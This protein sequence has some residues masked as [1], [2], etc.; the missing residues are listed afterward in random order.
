M[1]CHTN[2]FT[3]NTLVEICL[4]K[5]SNHPTAVDGVNNM[6]NNVV[7]N[8]VA[9]GQIRS[10]PYQKNGPYICPRCNQQL[11][12][13]QRF[14]AHARSHYKYESKAQRKSRLMS[15]IRKRDLCFQMINGQ[16]ILAPV[17]SDQAG[18]ARNMNNTR[19]AHSGGHELIN[20]KV[21]VDQ[22]GAAPLLE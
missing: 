16:L 21:E 17:S 18:E 5:R 2:I 6:N 3:N 12:S 10:L 19:F 4:Q 7:S 11:S 1:S 14:A 22:V 9:D 20:V 13:P 15:K 8:D